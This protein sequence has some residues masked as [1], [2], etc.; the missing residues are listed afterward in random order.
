M[1]GKVLFAKASL[2]GK[3]LFIGAGVSIIII[4]ATAIILHTS[5]YHYVL[6]ERILRKMR[7]ISRERADIS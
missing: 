5:L 4:P 7:A 6:F 3:N 1:Y 2:D